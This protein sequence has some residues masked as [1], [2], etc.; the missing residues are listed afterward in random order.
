MDGEGLFLWPDL[1]KYEGSYKEDKK[2]GYG[3]FEWYIVYNPGM[4]VGYIKA[5]GK[6]ENNTEMEN[7]S[8]R[9]KVSGRKVF[10]MTVRD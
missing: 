1:R 8:P 7:F 9:K 6:M 10:G 4:M 2:E 3:V 5:I